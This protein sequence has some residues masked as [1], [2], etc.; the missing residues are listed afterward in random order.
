[1]TSKPHDCQ[2]RAPADLLP[3]ADPYITR[4][5]TDHP[6]Q[7]WCREPGCRVHGARRY[8]DHAPRAA[9]GSRSGGRFLQMDRSEGEGSDSGSGAAGVLIADIQ[10]HVGDE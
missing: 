8:A 6:P 2:H 5:F 7:D 3:W 4:L 9:G 1:M 10:D